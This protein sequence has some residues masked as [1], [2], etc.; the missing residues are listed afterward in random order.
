MQH[1]YVRC[2]LKQLSLV[3]QAGYEGI[4]AIIARILHLVH[5]LMMI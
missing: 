2:K 4:V 1:P 5:M 3:V